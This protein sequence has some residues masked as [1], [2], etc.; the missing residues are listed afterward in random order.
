[1]FMKFSAVAWLVLPA[2]W[3]FE[4]FPGLLMR[5]WKLFY[6]LCGA[7][8]LTSVIFLYFLP[9]SPKFLLAKGK[10]VEAIEV[11][12][13]MYLE[14]HKKDD[15]FPF[16][17]VKRNEMETVGKLDDNQNKVFAVVKLLWNQTAPLLKKPHRVNF[18][19]LL[20]S[21]CATVYW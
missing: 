15:I 9:E 17:R 20:F 10:S 4:L 18:I 21:F 7:P 19:L 14:N 1:M 2:K 8:G 16:K 13:R 5:P 12:Q 11:I 3:Q 6:A